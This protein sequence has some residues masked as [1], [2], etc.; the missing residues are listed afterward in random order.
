VIGIIIPLLQEAEV[1]NIQKKNIKK[2]I[3]ISDNLTVFISGVGEENA[4]NAVTVLA[5]KVTHLISWGTAAGLSKKLKAGDLLLPNFIASKN[6]T[7]FKTDVKFNEKLAQLLPNNILIE[8]G[9][10]SESTSILTTEKEKEIF[11]KQT[12]AVACDMESASIAK[13]AKTYKIPFNAIRFVTDDFATCIPKT[14]NLSIDKNGNFSI[15]KFLYH[16]IL[17]PKDIKHVIVLAKNFNKAKKSM[18]QLKEALLK[19]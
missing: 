3:Q 8:N 13:L 15:S 4:K 12:N 5:S 14:V 11:Q 16:I 10:I 2:P 17:N 6:K 19:L 1:F 18:Y 9:L 7:S